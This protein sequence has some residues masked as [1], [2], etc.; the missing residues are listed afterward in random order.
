MGTMNASIPSWLKYS[1]SLRS[2]CEDSVVIVAGT[3]EDDVTA[4]KCSNDERN[5]VNLASLKENES[6]IINKKHTND[7]IDLVIR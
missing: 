5:G 6:I 3:D 4:A 1:R 2:L 7:A